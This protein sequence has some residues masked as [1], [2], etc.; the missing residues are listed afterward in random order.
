MRFGSL[1]WLTCNNLPRKNRELGIFIGGG[2]HIEGFLWVI[3][4]NLENSKGCTDALKKRVQAIDNVMLREKNVHRKVTLKIIG[5]TKVKNLL[6]P[7]DFAQFCK[8]HS[9]EISPT[10]S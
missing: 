1:I 2:R 4:V 10:S 8:K 9:I 5:L 7:G 3:G 6:E